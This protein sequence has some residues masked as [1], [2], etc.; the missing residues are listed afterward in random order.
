MF[1]MIQRHKTPSLWMLRSLA[2]C[3][4]I[5]EASS[6][7]CTKNNQLLDDRK[8]L[9]KCG[10]TSQTARPQATAAVGLAFRADDAFKALHTE[11]FMSSSPPELPDVVK[12]Q[13]FGGSAN[14]QVVQ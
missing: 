5:I 1:L 11:A 7:G 13:D 4:N 12:P 3:S 10:F 6:S 8:T 9:D 2:P 14:E